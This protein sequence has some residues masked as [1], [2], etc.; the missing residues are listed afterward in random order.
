MALWEKI[1]LGILVALVV[2]WVLP[3]LKQSMEQRRD[4]PSDWGSVA[5]PLGAVVLFVILLLA[6]QH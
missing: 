4:A 2:L 5:L 3:G 6:A 1:V